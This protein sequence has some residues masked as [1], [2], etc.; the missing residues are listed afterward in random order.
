MTFRTLGRTIFASIVVVGVLAGCAARPSQN[1]YD[2]SEVGKATAVTFGTVI[3]SRQVDITG[4][5]TG[6]GALVGAAVGAGAGSYV[7]QGSGNA[8][9]IGAGLLAGALV[10]AAVEQ[11]AADRTGVE[12]VVTLES[13]VTLTVVQDIGKGE[14]ILPSGMRV[15]VQNSGGYQRVL[16][17]EALPTEIQRPKGIKVVD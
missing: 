13:G 17:A 11:A 7:G 3:T 8:W 9:A 1:V 16:P 14:G 2:H 5:N 10:G 15:M 12:Y 6:G 4:E